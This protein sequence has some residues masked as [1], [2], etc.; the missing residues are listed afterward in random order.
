VFGESGKQ[1][2]LYPGRSLSGQRGEAIKPT[3]I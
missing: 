2:N 3:Y 1:E